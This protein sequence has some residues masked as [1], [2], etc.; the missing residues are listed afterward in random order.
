MCCSV[1]IICSHSLLIYFF[2]LLK[3]DLCMLTYTCMYK[4]KH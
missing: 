4:L 1:I 3:T 2:K